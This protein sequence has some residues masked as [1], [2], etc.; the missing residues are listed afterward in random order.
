V[1]P[2]FIGLLTI[3][4]PLYTLLLLLEKL[5]EAYKGLRTPGVVVNLNP[6]L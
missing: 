5:T 1:N 6:W 3:E 4:R 2:P